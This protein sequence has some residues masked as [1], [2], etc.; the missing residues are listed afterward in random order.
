MAIYANN[1]ATYRRDQQRINEQRNEQRSNRTHR[2]YEAMRAAKPF[3]TTSLLLGFSLFG[4]L[5]TVY[6]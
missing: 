2:L 6:A 1:L 3:A 5:H 4:L